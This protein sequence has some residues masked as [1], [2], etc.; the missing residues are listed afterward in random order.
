MIKYIVFDNEGRTSDRYTIFDRRS[1]DIFAAWEENSEAGMTGRYIGNCA[2]HRITLYGAGWRQMPLNQKIV[3]AETSN[4]VHNAQLN[5]HW[6]GKEMAQQ[7]WPSNLRTY[8][9]SLEEMPANKFTQ[10]SI[11]EPSTRL[12]S[13]S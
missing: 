6:L 13:F 2:E 9:D 7:N 11:C 3:E 4:Y 5:P 8:I 10:S 1:G 12:Q